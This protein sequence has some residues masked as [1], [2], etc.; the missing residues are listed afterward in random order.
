MGRTRE[1]GEGEVINT[2][3]REVSGRVSSLLD[4]TAVVQLHMLS[5]LGSHFTEG[6]G[7]PN[8]WYL[9]PS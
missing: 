4:L 3:A 2:D 5:Y 8:L 9:C 7:T 6:R 1:G